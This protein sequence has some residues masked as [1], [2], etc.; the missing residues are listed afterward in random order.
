MSQTKIRWWEWPFAIW[1]VLIVVSYHVY[2]AVDDFLRK[3]GV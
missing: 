2:Q 3:E 1:V